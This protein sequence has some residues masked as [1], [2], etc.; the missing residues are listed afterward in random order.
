MTAELKRIPLLCAAALYGAVVRGRNL[1]FDLGIRKSTET[2]LPVVSVGNI[3]AGGT[4]KT[5]LVDLIAKY[6]AAR[7]VKTAILSRGY[8]RSTKGARLVSDGGA[9][10]LGSREAGDET[11]MLA[12]RN[13]GTPVVV[14]EKR[15]VGMAL[16]AERF[17]N[18]PPDIVILDD[19]FQHRQLART[20]DI[21]VVNASRPLFDDR[22]LPAGRLR[23][24]TG[25]LRRADLIVL[26]KLNRPDEAD[27]LAKKLSL[28]GKPLI[29]TGMENGEPVLFAGPDPG[30]IPE[31]V[32]ALAGIGEP[33][34]FVRSLEKAGMKTV[35]KALYPDHAEFPLTAM[36]L[37]AE[38]AAGKKLAI[39]TT[40][41]DYFRIL[42]N[43]ALPGILS[44]AP[45]YYLPVNT[46]IFEGKELLERMLDDVLLS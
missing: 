7:G 36:K 34:S 44:R 40:E 18:D 25:N 35:S 37:L 41:K 20:L 12:H 15:T 1:L 30:R 9:V 42:G 2:T 17:A 13:S 4:G 46:V 23:E 32:V 5:P 27:R 21:V 14:A 28:F 6:Y 10:L 26:G 11:A 3:T 22:M 19:G 39:V 38:E 43:P 24:P 16:I 8:G 45:C 33:E 29:R 31:C